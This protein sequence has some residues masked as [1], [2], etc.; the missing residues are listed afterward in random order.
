MPLPPILLPPL[1][2]PLLLPSMLLLPPPPGV[3]LAV[4]LGCELPFWPEV[5]L[6]KR[7]GGLQMQGTGRSSCACVG[8][9][10][11]YVVCLV[12]SFVVHGVHVMMRWQ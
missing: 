6:K 5:Q 4:L 8:A 10:L 11:H 12:A 3:L 9:Q 2:P 7:G 1:P